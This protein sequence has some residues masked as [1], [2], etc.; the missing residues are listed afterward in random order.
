[1]VPR[2]VNQP[3]F[4]RTAGLGSCALAVSKAM[5]ARLSVWTNLPAEFGGHR[6]D[7]RVQVGGQSALVNPS[8]TSVSSHAANPGKGHLLPGRVW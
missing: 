6:A 7:V 1:M 5:T 8:M 4:F 2:G 3:A